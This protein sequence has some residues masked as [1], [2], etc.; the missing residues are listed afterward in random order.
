MRKALFAGSFNPFTIGHRDLTERGLELFD[1]IVIA[2]GYNEQKGRSPE[3]ERELHRVAAEFASE[4]RVSVVSYTGLTS[5]FARECGATCLLRG[6]R[7]VA[8]YE[9]ERKLA[10]ANREVFGIDTVI[11][12]ASPRYSYISSSMLRELA[13]NGCDI[14]KFLG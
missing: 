13:H 11:L 5:E 1:E 12:V 10:D 9:Y 3:M 14:E 8:D 7:D 4:S 2:F 6:V